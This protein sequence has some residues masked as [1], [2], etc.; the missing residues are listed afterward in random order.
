MVVPNLANKYYK[1]EISPQEL[2]EK[3][4]SELGAKFIPQSPY[5]SFNG[6]VLR[7]NNIEILISDQ[8]NSS[9]ET[10]KYRTL[11]VATPQNIEAAKEYISES[12]KKKNIDF[13]IGGSEESIEGLEN[14][15]LIHPWIRHGS[16]DIL[17]DFIKCPEIKEAHERY[18]E[19]SERNLSISFMPGRSFRGYNDFVGAILGEDGTQVYFM[20]PERGKGWDTQTYCQLIGNKKSLDIISLKLKSTKEDIPWHEFRH[21]T[22]NYS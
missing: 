2:K 8:V 10:L 14:K 21:H 9:E 18:L 7:D 13:S 16:Q 20:F 19:H 12:I 11:I 3:F 4:A 15:I 5:R 17:F 22:D 1:L 6:V